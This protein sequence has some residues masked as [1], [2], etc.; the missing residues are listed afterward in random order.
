MGKDSD[1]DPQPQ[2]LWSYAVEITR[3]TI[4]QTISLKEW[5]VKVIALVVAAIGYCS[6]YLLCRLAHLEGSR[7]WAL[8]GLAVLFVWGALKTGYKRE[9]SL[10]A[11]LAIATGR[12][13]RSVQWPDPS[14][15]K[16]IAETT[17][18]VLD[19]IARSGHESVATMP[20]TERASLSPLFM[21]A[22]SQIR[23][24]DPHYRDGPAPLMDG[25]TL[26]LRNWTSFLAVNLIRSEHYQEG[27]PIP[28]ASVAHMR[29]GVDEVERLCA[30][31]LD[32]WGVTCT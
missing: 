14:Y 20:A 5:W 8:A 1:P 3:G 24:A 22:I 10:K 26:Q 13:T 28:L 31:M 29:Q 2:A 23:S 15:G 4:D 6:P 21:L 30:E 18:A 12:S 32:D 17:R 9:Q 19:R 25:R 27:D 11:K 7:W 16:R